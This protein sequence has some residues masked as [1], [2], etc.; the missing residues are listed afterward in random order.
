MMLS[1]RQLV[2]AIVGG[3]A[4][5]GWV[6]ADMMPAS[7]A[8]N[9][10]RQAVCVG[11]ETQDRQFDPHPL[12]GGPALASLAGR[13]PLLPKAEP[14][15]G[16]TVAGQPLQLFNDGQ[17]SL[18]LCLYT[19]M[20]VGLFRAG[21]WVKRPT[22][23]FASYWCHDGGP[24]GTADTLSLDALPA[25]LVQPDCTAADPPPQYF[26]GLISPL[27]HKSQFTPTTRASRAP[28]LA[29]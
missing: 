5:A 25:C 15:A 8:N 18:D 23:G 10:D 13:I 12:A 29:C 9:A 21:H 22:I 3:L 28:P 27:L 7:P 14:D 17:R 19:L 2:V 20:G 16:P 4:L 6:R 1:P 24:F 11:Q 26:Q